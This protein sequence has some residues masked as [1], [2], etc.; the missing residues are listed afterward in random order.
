M[1]IA[2][3]YQSF[4]ANRIAALNFLCAVNQIV[5]KN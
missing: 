1:P 4:E 3:L 2:S 5:G